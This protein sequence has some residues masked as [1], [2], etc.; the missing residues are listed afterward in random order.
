MGSAFVLDD[1]APRF[2]R[3]V[4]SDGFCAMEADCICPSEV[5][6]YNNGL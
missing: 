4:D 2:L 5:A 6:D 3:E 1:E